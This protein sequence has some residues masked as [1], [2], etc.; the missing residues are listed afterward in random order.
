MGRRRKSEPPGL[1][2]GR[3]LPI[4]LAALAV[5]LAAPAAAQATIGSAGIGD[6]LFPAAG[7]GGYDVQSYALQIGY[8]PHPNALRGDATI[9]A[10]ATEELDRFD[11]DLRDQL[12]VSSVLVNG[13]P[14]RFGQ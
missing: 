3:A 4:A 13:N 9:D 10:R 5:L 8:R 11:L 14:A 6:A 1:D 2:R 12:R 7:N